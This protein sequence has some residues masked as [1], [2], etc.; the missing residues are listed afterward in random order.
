MK[1][2]FP[3]NKVV[4]V[5]LRTIKGE[6]SIDDYIAKHSNN[7]MEERRAHKEFQEM[8]KEIQVAIADANSMIIEEQLKR[9][10]LIQYRSIFYNL[11]Q[12][13]EID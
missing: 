6:I 2:L 13:T 9:G 8:S 7:L 4:K 12:Q 11:Q 1:T 3:I 5:L 10:V